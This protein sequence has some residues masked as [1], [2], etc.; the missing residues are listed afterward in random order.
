MCATL[1][2]TND[3]YSVPLVFHFCTAKAHGSMYVRKYIKRRVAQQRAISACAETYNN[4]DEPVAKKLLF[5]RSIFKKQ[6]FTTECR[7]IV[8]RRASTAQATRSQHPRPT[9]DLS[10]VLGID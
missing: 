5:C 3:S 8:A 1:H 7:F 6:H 4:T 10:S 9:Q 2:V